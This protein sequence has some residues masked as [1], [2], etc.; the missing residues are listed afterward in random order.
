MAVA[1][2]PARDRLKDIFGMEKFPLNE[3]GPPPTPD[4]IMPDVG[5]WS[6][7]APPRRVEVDGVVVEGP[8][9]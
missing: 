9:A 4:M 8:E 1:H 5:D 3:D 7:K 2:K 6:D